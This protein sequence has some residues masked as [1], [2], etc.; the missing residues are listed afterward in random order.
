MSEAATGHAA[1]GRVRGFRPPNGDAPE[2]VTI[3]YK[4]HGVENETEVLRETHAQQV[5]FSNADT[6][7][8]F[9]PSGAPIHVDELLDVSE[10]AGD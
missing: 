3:R 8:F 7:R 4:R 5:E 10:V 9:T 1:V 2:T 6:C